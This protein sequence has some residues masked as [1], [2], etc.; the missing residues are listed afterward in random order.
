MVTKARR[1]RLYDWKFVSDYR[2]RKYRRPRHTSR[3]AKIVLVG[4]L[5][6][7]SIVVGI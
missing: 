3:G 7:L 5:L 4:M 2:E 1:S 6:L